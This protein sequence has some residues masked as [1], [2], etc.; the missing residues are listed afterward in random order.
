MK[1][2]HLPPSYSVHRRSVAAPIYLGSIRLHDW[3]NTARGGM[4]V[5]FGIRDVGPSEV[6]PYK[7]L[8]WGKEFGQRMRVWIGPHSDTCAVEQVSE[9]SHY[10]GEAVLLRWSDDSVNGMS[11]KLLLDNGPDGA[12]GLH[13]F[14]GFTTGR[15]EGD[16]FNFVSWALSDD[17]RL[18]PSNKTRRKTPFAELSSV[19]QSN[20]LCRDKQFITFLSEYETDIVRGRLEVRPETDPVDF[21]STAVRRYLNVESRS[22][23]NEESFDGARTRKAWAKLYS[24]FEDFKRGARPRSLTL[25]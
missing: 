9:N 8:P 3:R 16:L 17:E 1:P 11:L 4:T 5:D 24:A 23:M 21:A 2:Q 25:I 13:P 10:S 18:V 20:I 22:V 6:H 12:R 15:R 7:G 19:K 14:E